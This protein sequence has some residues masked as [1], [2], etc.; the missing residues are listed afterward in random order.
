MK[1]WLHARISANRFGGIPEDYIAIHNWFDS[2]KA[3]IAD[4]RHRMILHNAFGIFLCEQVF[5]TPDRPYITNSDGKQVQIRDIGEQHVLDDLG[6]IP[7]LSRCFESMTIEQW[8]GGPPRK[9]KI[10]SLEQ[11]MNVLN[12]LLTRNVD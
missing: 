10:L 12:D 4:V 7:P 6:T 8:M 5:G 9:R 2:T 3:A 11:K 1:P